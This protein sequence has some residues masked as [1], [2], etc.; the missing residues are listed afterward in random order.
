MYDLVILMHGK[1]ECSGYLFN[2]RTWCFHHRFTYYYFIIV[3]WLIHPAIVL[4]CERRTHD[5][6]ANQDTRV[7]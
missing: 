4:Y 5:G 7:I 1:N 3:R 6:G 2:E